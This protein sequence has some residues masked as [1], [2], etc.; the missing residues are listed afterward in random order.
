MLVGEILSAQPCRVLIVENHIPLANLLVEILERECGVQ[1][2][3]LAR[4]YGEAA[5]YLAQDKPTIAV[6]DWHLPDLCGLETAHCLRERFPDTR[7]ILL[8]D[9]DEHRYAQ[10]ALEQGA[11]AYICK[12]LIATDL[13]PALEKIAGGTS[14]K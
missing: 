13:I 11:A 10:V 2:I 8:N 3:G 5:P 14:L 1:V 6:V 12:S 4:S 7:L 9:E